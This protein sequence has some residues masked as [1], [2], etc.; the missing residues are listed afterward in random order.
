MIL[1]HFG[2]NKIKTIKLI[3]AF[4]I[5]SLVS[6]CGAPQ[7]FSAG[8]FQH[9]MNDFMERKK[10]REALFNQYLGMTTVEIESIFGKP[11]DIYK[12]KPPEYNLP[13]NGDVLWRYQNLSRG[14]GH[15]YDF[16]FKN[17]RLILVQVL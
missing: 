14:N 15:S 7:L 6:G 13:D 2:S 4:L 12:A 11:A 10:Q 5:V 1:D 9:D 16:I 8:N 17:D 3:S